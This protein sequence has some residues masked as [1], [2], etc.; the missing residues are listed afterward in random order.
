MVA[1]QIGWLIGSPSVP[2]VV[3]VEGRW[4]PSLFT[5]TPASAVTGNMMTANMMASQN[6]VPVGGAWRIGLFVAY[7]IPFFDFN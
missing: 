6:Q 4:A 3:G 5:E 1:L 7:Y 2:F